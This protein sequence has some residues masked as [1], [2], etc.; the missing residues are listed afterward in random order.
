MEDTLEDDI[1]LIDDDSFIDDDV[2][3]DLADLTIMDADELE[4]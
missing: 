2:E 4:E 3:D 1:D